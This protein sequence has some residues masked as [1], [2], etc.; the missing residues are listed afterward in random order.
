MRD[1]RAA[2]ELTQEMFGELMGV[3]GQSVS[4]YEGGR[5]A[6]AR[7][8]LARLADRLGIPVAAFQSGGP[9]P[10]TL[11][12]SPAVTR[13]SN[14][15]SLGRVEKL[16]REIALWAVDYERRGQ[17]ISASV[18]AGWMQQLEDAIRSEAGTPSAAPPPAA[19]PSAPPPTPEAGR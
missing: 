14:G 16:K 13:P 18:V 8:R 17:A 5:S 1:L 10:S 9:M 2:L 7:S 4:D 11:L 19:P 12:G 3:T 6:P 15:A